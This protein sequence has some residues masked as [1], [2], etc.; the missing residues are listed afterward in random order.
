MAES[1]DEC[2]NRSKTKHLR[3]N[4]P[5]QCQCSEH[6]KWVPENC[7]HVILDIKKCKKIRRSTLDSL[8]SH[9]LSLDA[10]SICSLCIEK[11]KELELP[12]H[13]SEPLNEDEVIYKQINSFYEWLSETPEVKILSTSLMMTAMNKLMKKFGEI[14]H[15]RIYFDG[16]Q[17]CKVYKS[18]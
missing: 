9:Q 2:G 8:K 12:I 18:S 7:D 17:L 15:K 1:D 4:I 10:N 5:K 6:T 3:Y 13:E 11:V 14:I 16:A